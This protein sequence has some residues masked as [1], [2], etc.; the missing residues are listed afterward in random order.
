M[1]K[2]TT[3]ARAEISTLSDSELDQV[4][5]GWG[6]CGYGRKNYG[7]GYG[8]GGC[9]K[10]DYDYGCDKGNNDYGHKGSRKDVQQTANVFVTVNQIA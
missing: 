5:G 7:Y 1:T 3:S 8:Y 9:D 6:H 2:N 10:R 4:V